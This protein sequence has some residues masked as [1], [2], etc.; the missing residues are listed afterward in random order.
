MLQ[1]FLPRCCIDL[2]ARRVGQISRTQPSLSLHKAIVIVG[3][4]QPNMQQDDALKTAV[5]G[6]VNRVRN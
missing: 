5:R 6:R 4:N 2:C 3:G 1:F